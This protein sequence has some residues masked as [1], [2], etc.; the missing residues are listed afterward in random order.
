LLLASSGGGRD[1]QQADEAKEFNLMSNDTPKNK[2]FAGSRVVGE[3][4]S[5]VFKK[6]IS[7]SIH[8]LRKPRAIALDVD[9]LQ[10]AKRYGAV[11]IEITDRETGKV[12]SADVEHFARFS[13]ELN[14]GYGSQRALILDRWTV[15]QGKH[16]NTPLPI[17][18]QTPAFDYS[19]TMTETH[20]PGPVQYSLFEVVTK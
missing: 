13:F 4:V 15:T 17:A 12:Y 11:T 5:G 20:E 2:I 1:K 7:G 14:R 18:D 8:F 19:E 16:K 10:Q 9:S 3:V 6:I